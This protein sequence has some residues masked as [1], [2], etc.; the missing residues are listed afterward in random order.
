MDAHHPSAAPSGDGRAASARSS[1]DLTAAAEVVR[2]VTGPDGTKVRWLDVGEGPAVVLIHA[3]LF[4]LSM[5]RPVVSRLSSRYR[6]AILGRRGY[7][8]TPLEMPYSLELECADVLSVLEAV[9][10]PRFVVGYSSGA[11]V[12]LMAAAL[13][14]LD[15]LVLFEPPLPVDGPLLGDVLAEADACV[16]VGDVLQAVRLALV[17]GVGVDAARVDAL[18]QDPQSSG[19]FRA[20]GAAWIREFHWIDGL[21]AADDAVPAVT[22]PTTVI[23]GSRTQPHH[24]RAA[25]HLVEELP[26]ARLVTLPDQGHMAATTAPSLLA[27]VIIGCLTDTG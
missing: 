11:L 21:G 19:L 22:G 26:R 12:A 20:H 17:H 14:P 27:E 16:A 1:G 9:A 4:G 2:E 7:E 23:V 13:T 24:L 25:R 15:Q 6:C 18:C 10:P 3:G 5:W 8:L